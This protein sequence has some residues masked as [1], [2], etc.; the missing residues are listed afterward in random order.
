M[1]LAKPVLGL[2]VGGM[3][4]LLDG[5]SGF[6]EPALAP[7]MGS[8]ITFSLL[9]G[10]VAGVATGYVSERVHSMLLGMLAGIAIAALLSLLVIL[11][12]GMA[13]FWDIMI[14]G[15]LLG[16]IVG[17]ATQRFGRAARTAAAAR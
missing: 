7:V 8:V 2:A 17:F 3:L 14:P 11:R 6:F 4:G 16:A 12:A 9:K 13:L 1:S 10:L 15:M 5:L